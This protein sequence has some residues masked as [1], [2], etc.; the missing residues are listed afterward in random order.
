MVWQKLGTDTLTVAG[1]EIT[2]GTVVES[3]VFQTMA[4]YIN[5][6]AVEAQFHLNDVNS[7]TPYAFR[8][9]TDG[10]ADTT[11]ASR[12]YLAFGDY[13]GS[14]DSSFGINYFSN[15]TTEEKLDVGFVIRN[16]TAGA[17]NVP[18]RVEMVGKDSQ[19]TLSTT[20]IDL[21]NAGAG[22]FAIDSNLSALG[23]VVATPAAVGGWVEIGRTTLG[24]PNT[25]IDVSGLANKR[26]LMFLADWETSAGSSNEHI[27][28]NGLQTAIYADRRSL[29]GLADGVDINVLG[30]RYQATLTPVV[31]IP[32]FNV[33][34]LA[35]V[36]NQEKLGQ[37][38]T[39]QQNTLGAG[40]VP[41]RAEAVNKQAQTT[42][43]IDQISLVGETVANTHATGSEVVILEWSPEDVHTTNFWEELANIQV[44]S[45]SSTN[46]SSGTITAKKYL[47]IQCFSTGTS[48]DINTTFNNDTGNN[49]ARRFSID[50]T[51]DD[52]T[53]SQS[54]I[55]N[56]HN[57]GRPGENA[58]SN[59]F[60]INNSSDEKLI[61]GKSIQQNTAGS[62]NAPARVEFSAKWANTSV[63]ITEVDFDSTSGN[64]S[65]GSFLKVW[66]SN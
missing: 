45:S 58:F 43:P 52:T 12:N 63:Q 7:G 57:A 48:S 66:G 11:A 56:M 30:S 41:Q 19:T 39:V 42:N 40:N 37:Y 15:V 36:S 47:W 64:F 10:G 25:T 65:G 61:T 33:G 55:S 27:I 21:D 62:A 60:I 44:T 20:K 4:H 17:G 28:F 38:W 1:D 2:T 23:D 49:Y 16:G 53:G 31:G 29:N 32:Q 24:S 51:A 54:S 35:N 22:D 8:Y 59:W 14:D 50:G 26:Y 46:L 9:S 6:G 3:K 13:T 34:Y 18:G 5:S